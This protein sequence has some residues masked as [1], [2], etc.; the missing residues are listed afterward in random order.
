MDEEEKEIRLLEAVETIGINLGRIADALS[1]NDQVQSIGFHGL[2]EIAN[3][4]KPKRG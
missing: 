4:I 1:S 2:D 3:A